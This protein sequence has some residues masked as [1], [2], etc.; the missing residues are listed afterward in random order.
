MLGDREE[1]TGNKV[2]T[3]LSTRL[4]EK[5][6]KILEILQRLAEAS[7]CG[8]LV[9]VEGKKD[10]ETLRKLGVEGEIITAK[11]GGK[12][13]LDVIHEINKKEKHE[14]ILLLDHDR[15]GKQLTS[16]LKQGF[17]RQGIPSNM[18]FWSELFMFVGK[19]VKDI[20]GLASYM[21]TL[22]SKISGNS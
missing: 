18:L 15:R 9:I 3:F 14:V 12:S 11:T 7:A 5:E 8:A 20:E 22:N 4:R 17:E 6:E 21:E 19:E 16:M 10:V 13:L 2:K 1:R